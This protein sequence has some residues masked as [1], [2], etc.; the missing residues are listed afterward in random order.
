MQLRV[1]CWLKI[2]HLLH[3]PATIPFWGYP[4]RLHLYLTIF[5]FVQYQ[6]Y[7]LTY[8]QK[9]PGEGYELID[10][11]YYMEFL[12][13]GNADYAEWE[14]LFALALK[15]QPL[16]SIVGVYFYAPFLPHYKSLTII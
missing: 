12:H 7:V 10:R 13:S 8:S 11:F 15:L 4:L 5:Q 6:F 9:H 2:P 14:V 1:V 16:S 3:N